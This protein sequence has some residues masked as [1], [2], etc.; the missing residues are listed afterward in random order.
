MMVLTMVVGFCAQAAP[1]SSTEANRVVE[2]PFQADRPHANPFIEVEFDVVVTDPHGT[3]MTVPGFWAGADRWAVRYASPIVG[4]HRYC[5]QCSDTDDA[6][7][8]RVEG[9]IEIKPYSGENLLYRHGP[10]RVARDKR[11]FDHADGT[12]FLW[13]GDT[14]KVTCK[15]ISRI[16]SVTC[17][18]VFCSAAQRA[19]LMGPRGSGTAAWKGIPASVRYTIGRRGDRV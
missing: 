10:I 2:I 11:H 18:G 15:R 13:L 3:Q 7:L 4:T 19:T 16:I 8:H 6:G 14:W 12:P 1:V 5:T 9:R 17:S